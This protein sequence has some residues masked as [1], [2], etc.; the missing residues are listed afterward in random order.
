MNVYLE[1]VVQKVS[2]AVQLQG[3]T[4]PAHQKFRPE[5]VFKKVL[6]TGKSLSE[7]LLFAEHV[8]YINCSECQNQ[9]S[10]GLSLEFSCI[11]LVI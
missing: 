5:K 10:P 9:F 7:A 2:M 3:V 8:V 1:I 11:E 6:G 4:F